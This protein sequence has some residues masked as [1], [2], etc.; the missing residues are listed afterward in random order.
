MKKQLLTL[1]LFVFAAMGILSA[2]TVDPLCVDGR[3]YF[4]IKDNAALNVAVQDG[5][6]NPKDV[7]FLRDITEKYKITDLVMPFISAESDIL[8]RTFRMDF[9]NQEMVEQ[10]VKELGQHPDIEYAEKAPLFFISLVPNDPYYNAALS[11]GMWG[12]ANSSWHLNLINASQAWDV[13]TGDPNIVVAVLDNAIW[14]DHPDLANKVVAAVDLANGDNDP[15]PP[16]AT[17]IWSHGTHSA[18]LIA[19]ETNNGVGV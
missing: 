14:V 11:G 8:Q 1:I 12:S 7:Y 2:Q 5:R 4:K 9:D 3:I 15:N 16:E 19:A 6:I 10:L 13:T 17:Y 18:G